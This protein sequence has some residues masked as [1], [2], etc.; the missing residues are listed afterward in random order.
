MSSY[1]FGRFADPNRTEEFVFPGAC[2]CP[3]TP[4]EQDTARVR[5]MI[6]SSAK[7]RIGRAELEGAVRLDPLA[8]HRQV[9]LEGV[10]SWNLLWPNPNSEEDDPAPVPV[11]INE[12][13]IELLGDDLLPLAEFADGLW[14]GGPV[15]NAS[16]APSRGLRSGSASP[17]RRKIRTPGT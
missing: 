14:S 4:H 8:A 15:P 13:T 1:N 5:V 17:T 7:A 6:G 3:G 10:T 16:G 11:P 2:R 9:V 12:G